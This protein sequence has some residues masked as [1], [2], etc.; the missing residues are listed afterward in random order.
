MSSSEL[1]LRTGYLLP[2]ARTRALVALGMGM[3]RVGE[4]GDAR[5]VPLPIVSRPCTPWSMPHPAPF[6]A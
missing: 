1:A 5:A 3:V 4:A 2:R 6:L